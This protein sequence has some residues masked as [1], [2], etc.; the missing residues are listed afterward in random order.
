M[1]GKKEKIK[2]YQMTCTSCEKRV[3][4]A[5]RKLEGVFHVKVS[6]RGEYA[7]VEFDDEVCSLDSIKEAIKKA[8]Y[9][10][11]NS[12]DYKFIGI[13][14]IATTIILLGLKTSGF[15]MEEKLQNASYAVLFVVGL[16]T[17][18][19]CVGMCGAL[20]LSQSLSKD[21]EGGIDSIKPALVYNLGRVVSYT[22]LGGLIG[23]FGS[24][25]SLSYKGKA[26]IQI[27]AGT[28]MLIM[29]LNMVG[30]KAFR[31]FQIRLPYSACKVKSKSDSAFI[32]GLLN[33]LM[34]CGPLQTMQLFAL[35]TG[36]ALKGA[37]SMLMFSLGTVPLMLTFGALSGV[38][39]QGHTKRILKLSGILIIVLGFIMGNRG[40]TMLGMNL[41]PFKAI[42][43]NSRNTLSSSPTN[44][45]SNP[46]IAK[47]EIKDGVQLVTIS[48]GNNGY[49]PYVVYV[50]KG[51]PVRW[52]ITGDKLN[53]CNN[54]II[55]PSLNIEMK[56][57][58]GENL[59]KEFTP[60]NTQDINFSCWMGM[61]GGVIKVVDSLD[62]VDTSEDEVSTA[63][64]NYTASCCTIN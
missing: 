3:E 26:A 56:L 58:K 2:V 10:T 6:Y 13:L 53:T 40:F 50:Q 46:Y 8:G 1:R 33:G 47:A 48:A 38:L 5:I 11:E 32:V 20:M 14:I 60:E 35:G 36:S 9:S 7:E 29:G 52:I 43:R 25:F 62:T 31:R 41:N 27:F 30:F 59:V 45:D 4:K 21:S 49:T 16:F 61:I 63:P 44:N 17:S 39:S 55:V 34:P 15:A 64:S 18:I 51:M 54:A 12:K 24:V 28:F 37:L 42:A 57:N 19:H 23:A 22:I